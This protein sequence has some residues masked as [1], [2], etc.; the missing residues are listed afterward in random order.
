MSAR[1]IM[2]PELFLGPSNGYS[3][4]P[5]AGPA[6][7]VAEAQ[8][9]AARTAAPAWGT[10]AWVAAEMA[11]HASA[12]TAPGSDL[13]ALALRLAGAVARVEIA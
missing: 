13:Q 12:I 2:T 6:A 4:T 10:P 9:L 1:Q 11:A 8:A 5:L 7:R 3:Y